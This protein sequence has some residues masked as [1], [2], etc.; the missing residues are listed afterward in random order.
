M[1]RREVHLT[2]V[3]KLPSGRA[4]A[5]DYK[6]IKLINIYAPSGTARKTERKHYYNTELPQILQAV[7]KDLLIGSY[8]N[9]VIHPADNTGYFQTSRAV[10]ELVRGLTLHDAWNKNPSRPTYTYYSSNGASRLDHFYIS[11]D[12]RS[13]K[14][15]MAVIPAAFTDHY[16]VELRITINDIDLKRPRCRWKMDPMLITAEILTRKISCQWVRW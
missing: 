12:L 1:A 7:H 4:V 14:T 10:T 6:G 15:G 3:T 9:C 2:N 13:R 11:P 5:V 8:F 16:A